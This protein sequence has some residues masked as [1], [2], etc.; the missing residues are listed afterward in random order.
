MRRGRGRRTLRGV[1]TGG[2]LDF[3]E[4]KPENASKESLAAVALVGQL[5]LAVAVPI[6][7]GVAGGLYI[8]DAV[9]GGWGVAAM[10]AGVF[11]GIGAA[12][13]LAYRLIAP[14]L[15]R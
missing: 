9:G 15:N 2:E 13:V 3:V 4:Q 14:F 5:G 1:P 12:L 11:V 10:L 6:V 8:K 7:A